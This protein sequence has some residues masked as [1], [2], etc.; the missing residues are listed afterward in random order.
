MRA[1][2]LLVL[3]VLALPA[4]GQ[5][6]RYTLDTTTGYNAALGNHGNTWDWYQCAQRNLKYGNDRLQRIEDDR[7]TAIND[8]DWNIDQLDTLREQYESGEELVPPTY[9]PSA[10]VAPNGWIVL[11]RVAQIVSVLTDVYTYWNENRNYN[12]AVDYA[13]IHNYYNDQVEALDSGMR[14]RTEY[15]VYAQNRINMHQ[16][17]VRA[18]NVGYMGIGN[19][20]A[21][22]VPRRGTVTVE[23]VA[24][25]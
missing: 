13:R 15:C 8:A 1:L 20:L 10:N 14:D 4:F 24:N 18:F 6:T 21:Y 22:P 19:W 17:E 7:V 9:P 2:I 5:S 11:R 23:C 12:A 16:H 3:M 25:C